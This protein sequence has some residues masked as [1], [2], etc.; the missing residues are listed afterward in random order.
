KKEN[1]KKYI[2]ENSN[3]PESAAISLRN[4]G[5]ALWFPPFLNAN[6]GLSH[7][8]VSVSSPPPPRRDRRGG[9]TREGASEAEASELGFASLVEPAPAA[10]RPR[11]CF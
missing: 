9:E 6:P 3:S 1:K 4:T 7:L 5:H 8:P 11:F 10:T 2:V